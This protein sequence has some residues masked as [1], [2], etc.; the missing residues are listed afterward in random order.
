[1]HPSFDSRLWR[2]SAPGLVAFACALVFAT[3]LRLLDV[4]GRTG[5]LLLAA[6]LVAIPALVLATSKAQRGSALLVIFATASTLALTSYLFG[7]SYYVFYPADFLM[8]SETDYI[9]DILKFRSG[10]P[11]FSADANNESYTYTPG[12]QLLTYLLA[13][14]AGQSTSLPAF[15]V[16]Q[17]VYTVGAVVFAV[18]CCAL[19][20]EMSA[21]PGD[22]D[23][24]SSTTSITSSPAYGATLFSTLF[25]VATNSLTNP[26]IHNLHNDALAQLVSVF[27]YYLLLQYARTRDRRV[28]AAMLFI[29]IVGFLVKQ[30]LALWGGYYVLYLLLFDVPRS[31]KRIILFG[32]VAFA[33]LCAGIFCCYLIWGED[34]T[35][36]VFYVLSEHKVVPARSVQHFIDIR[37]YIIM[38]LA[39]GALLFRGANFRVLIGPWAVWLIVML[40]AVYTGGI[41]FMRHHMGPASLLAAV[42]L[43]AGFTQIARERV[44]IAAP[45]N[46]PESLVRTS[47]AFVAVALLASSGLGIL[48]SPKQP[49]PDD[50][51]RYM[52]AI[53]DQFEGVEVASVLLDLGSYAYLESGTVMMDRASPIGERGSTDT[54]DLSGVVE[55]FRSQRYAKLLL[56][57]YG[58][59]NFWYDHPTWPKP[60]GIQALLDER[61]RIVGTIPAVGA[62][63]SLWARHTPYGLEEITILVPRTSP[64]LPT[65]GATQASP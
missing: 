62:P 12:S 43:I 56:R 6:A 65:Q 54:G 34:F 31:L 51:Y 18:R 52:E 47:V 64:A 36:W 63:H 5:T 27:A 17:L 61:Y 2:D 20:V 46:F 10:Y 49:L 44:A 48:R 45:A 32:G 35:Y 23:A 22:E 42:W 8:W 19:L 24:T 13:S 26:F 37:A 1:M 3:A 15:R 55:R 11:I 16:V 39:G 60:S 28:L 38:G 25:L 33:I 59:D 29:P 21:T 58:T 4:G 40:L 50:A 57:N 9:N 14:L 30:N 7:V 41:N 53:N